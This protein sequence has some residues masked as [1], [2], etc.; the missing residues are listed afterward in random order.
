[1]AGGGK[2]GACRVK[3][4]GPPGAPIFTVCAVTSNTTRLPSTTSPVRSARGG[5]PSMDTSATPCPEARKGPATPINRKRAA[6]AAT[7]G[8]SA[9]AGARVNK[10][11]QSAGGMPPS[12]ATFTAP[13]A[14]PPDAGL[15]MGSNQATALAPTANH[16]KKVTNLIHIACVS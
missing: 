5:L 10:A 6:S 2:S 14:A 3:V 16:T 8:G 11:D 7:G 13:G 15:N 4:G 12:S 9:V 1:M